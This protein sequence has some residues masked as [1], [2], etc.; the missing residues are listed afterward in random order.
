MPFPGVTHALGETVIDA[1]D[2]LSPVGLLQ[3]PLNM[4]QRDSLPDYFVVKTWR[5]EWNIGTD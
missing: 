4:G 5:V 1:K 3:T 2:V